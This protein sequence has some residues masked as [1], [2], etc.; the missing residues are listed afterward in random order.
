MGDQLQKDTYLGSDTVWTP[1]EFLDEL[2]L[3]AQP[4][5]SG[6]LPGSS[7]GGAGG[8]R[9]TTNPISP[10]GVG[11]LPAQHHAQPAT[12]STPSSSASSIRNSIP[13]L[14]QSRPMA[15]QHVDPRD[16]RRSVVN[17]RDARARLAGDPRRESKHLPHVPDK[18]SKHMPQVVKKRIGGGKDYPPKPLPTSMA[19]PEHQRIMMQRQAYAAGVDPTTAGGDSPAAAGA[20]AGA[21]AG[22]PAGATIDPGRGDKKPKLRNMFKRT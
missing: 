16:P 19:K 14:S 3:L 9:R 2:R 8:A 13:V 12:P 1:S 11:S 5:G 15:T 21:Q 22:L 20:A 10:R 18:V 6:S 4:L 17:P 7:G